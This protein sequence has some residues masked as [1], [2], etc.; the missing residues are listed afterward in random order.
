MYVF[1]LQRI[2]SIYF[3]LSRFYISNYLYILRFLPW[4]YEKARVIQTLLFVAGLNTLLQSFLGT[5]LPA[6]IGGSFTFVLPTVAIVLS[7]R[8]SGIVDPHQVCVQFLW[9]SSYIVCNWTSF[10]NKI[11]TCNQS[12]IS[13]NDER[14]TRCP[15]SCISFTD[16]YW[17]FRFL[18]K[19][20][21]VGFLESYIQVHYY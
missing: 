12:E 10:T 9:L 2:L 17:I 13:Q 14:N 18:E 20:R 5:R 8:Y 7:N 16:C 1:L 19:Y 6:V 11:F 21:Q 15:Y 3:L 4:Q